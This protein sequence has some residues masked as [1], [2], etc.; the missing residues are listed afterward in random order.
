MNVLSLFDGMSCGQQA[1][2]RAGIKVDKYFASEIDKYAIQVTMANYPDTIQLGSV[3]DVKGSDLP[4]IDLLIGGS[5]CQ[6]FSFAGKRKGMS[7]KDSQDILTLNHY[8]RLKDEGFEFEGQSYLFWEYM[9]LLNEVKPTYFLLEN[10]MMSQ[11]WKEVLT[12][13]IGIDPIMINSAL[14]SAQNRKRLY[15]T[16]IGAVKE[17]L[18]GELKCGIQQPEDRGILL[19]DVLEPEV[20]HKYYVS[21][22]TNRRLKQLTGAH[23]DLVEGTML[24]CYNQSIHTEKSVTL[25][26]RTDA[27]GHTHIVHSLQRRSPDR[28]SLKNNKNAGG[29]GPLSRADGKTYCLDTINCQAVEIV[30]MRGR[31]DEN[32]KNIQQLEPRNDNKTN[33]LTTVQKDNLVVVGCDYRTD[34]GF[35]DRK[36]GKSGTLAARA[37]ED[38]S[39][40]QLV[41]EVRQLNQSGE[42]NNGT[43]PYQQNR[44]YDTEGISPALCK[45]KSDLM[46]NSSRIRK[47][48][49]VECERLQTVKDN[50]TAHVSNAQRYKMLGNGWTVDVIAHIFAYINK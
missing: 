33:C 21:V 16:N 40:G 30:A 41:R 12:G 50:Y 14:L 35:R 45:D 42:S 29:A 23:D 5:P 39:C 15:W 47:L 38:E 36:N 17:G 31:P 28:P 25:S 49:P 20:D 22:E 37:R 2:E 27:G 32:G 3:V 19:K 46:I 43:Q 26:T 1:L 44:V 11:K 48:T 13:A 6:S 34:E 18:F 7:T 8:L 10:V 4:K 9:R 24:D